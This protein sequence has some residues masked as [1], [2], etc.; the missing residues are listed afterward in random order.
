[1]NT[2]NKWICKRTQFFTILLL[3]FMVSNV[4]GQ[5]R[6]KVPF[7][8]R[9]S[10]LAPNPY[11][12][13]S[14][15]NLRGDFTMIGNANLFDNRIWS[16]SPSSAQADNGRN[17]YMTFY[18]LPGELSS[19]KNS[20]SSNLVHPIG[21]ELSCTKIVYVGLYWSGRG[22]NSDANVLGNGLDKS[23][24][25]LKLPGQSTYQNITANGI[26][27]GTTAED[28]IYTS[29]ADITDKVLALGTNAWGS[30]SV[31]D[32]ATSEGNGDAVGYFGG[33]G[34]VVVYENP[35]MKWRDITVFDGF[36]YIESQDENYKT[37]ILDISGFRAAQSG[38]INI[39]MGM[40]AGE[41][42]NPIKGDSFEIKL[43]N[44]TNWE[45]LTHSS[46]SSSNF[47][48]SSVLISP[49]TRM[50]NYTNNYGTDIVMF[51]L[52]NTNNKFINNGQ[53]S[54]SFRFGTSQDTYIIYNITF[55]VDAYVPDVEAENK[56]LTS[57]VTQNSNISPNQLL[58]FEIA[59][60][61]KG[62]E[63]I[64][65]GKLQINIPSTM[66]FVSASI[67]Q[68]LDV[69]GTFTWTHPNSTDPTITPGGTLT[70]VFDK[71]LS[72]GSLTNILGK[73]NYRL[74]VSNDCV[75]LTSSVSNCML[76]ASLN[77]KVTGIGLTSGSTVNAPLVR[78]YT[79]GLCS[80]AVFDDLKLNIVLG[81]DFLASCPALSSEGAKL[82]KVSCGNTSNAINRSDIES[83]YPAGT[84]FY[85]QEPIV[86][87]Y[88]TSLV[89]G[90]FPVSI[91]GQL[92]YAI[93][94][95]AQV[96]CYLKLKTLLENITTQPTVNSIKVCLGESYNVN[97]QISTVGQQRGLNL[98][99]FD[100][101]T[102]TTPLSSV[103]NP[104]QVGLY[105]YYVAEGVAGASSS[106]FG[107]KVEFTIEISALPQVS[108]LQNKWEFC[109]N[110]DATLLYSGS[111][112]NGDTISWQYALDA[113]NLVWQDLLNTSFS[114][115]V[116]V[117]LNNEL[118]VSHANTS[119]DKV[120]IRVKIRNTANCIVYSNTMQLSIKQCNAI[121]N[122]ALPSTAGK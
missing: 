26:Y 9:T 107:N 1:M 109:P 25:K 28:G 94:P 32:V 45:L 24:V 10:S 29:Y 89:V 40:M 17:S 16:N 2:Q 115:N 95:G 53:T 117:S 48:N 15:Y 93:I 52:G 6:N 34:M 11:T 120:F 3:L 111:I 100:S 49:N 61:N 46:N 65:E 112:G 66:H 71:N 41:G 18:K 50:P 87:G 81:N 60:R 110:A 14:I 31:A 64:K 105:T 103:P 54:T 113:Q 4:I 78:E 119:I 91:T 56:V 7:S 114:N 43:R 23:K 118:R 37:G 99:Y 98:Y 75:L 122:P 101:L 21:Y 68:S 108:T 42:D 69:K 92:F 90:D 5:V 58:D 76:N 83:Y 63:A 19:I 8:L 30:Y 59:L 88:E 116:L 12:N 38:N 20:S 33:W 96:G 55:A 36:S 121:S 57:N 13:K 104:T 106:C 73:L 72:A 102:S 79:Q 80:A 86:S 47:F 44:T 70:W 27:K 74:R 62:S 85:S 97:A 22:N 77:G 39:K 51:D 82:F 67:D 35:L 84:K